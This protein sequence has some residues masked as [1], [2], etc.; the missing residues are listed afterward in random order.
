MRAFREF[1]GHQKKLGLGKEQIKQRRDDS[2]TQTGISSDPVGKKFGRP[3][4]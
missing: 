1:F 3:S 4:V 2:A